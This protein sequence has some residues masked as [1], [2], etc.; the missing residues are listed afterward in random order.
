[1]QSITEIAKTAIAEARTAAE[2]AG[3]VEPTTAELVEM[4]AEAMAELADAEG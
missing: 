2:A 4:L 1:M 3:A